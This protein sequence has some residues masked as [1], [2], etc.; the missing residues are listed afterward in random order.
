MA[1]FPVDAWL[2]DIAAAVAREPVVL[3]KADPGAGKTTRVPPALLK[4]F[5]SVLVVEPRRLAAKLTASWVADEMGSPVGAKVGYQ[6][7][8]ENRASSETRLLFVT[9]GI[10]SRKMMG[11]PQLRDW[12]VVI[13]D[14]F[15]ERH[16]HTDLALALLRDAQKSRPDLRIVIMSATLDTSRL[17]EWLGRSVRF[18]IPGRTF[19]VTVEY[20]PGD[21]LGRLEDKVANSVRELLADGRTG[22]GNV[23]VFLPGRAEIGRA[24]QKLDGLS[25]V[26]VI[27]L[28]A[29]QAQNHAL[30]AR[31]NGRRKVVLSTNVAETSLTLPRITAVV[32]TGLA[33]ISGHAP[34]S[35][36]P[37]LT[38]QKISQASCVQRTGRAGRTSAG[39][40]HRL[41]TPMDFNNRAKFGEP[42]IRR[43]DLCQ[44]LLEIA[45]IK[46][47]ARPWDLLPWFE[48]PDARILEQ[49]TKLLERL[50]AID[51]DGALTREGEAMASL[52]LHPRL[53]RMVQ[54]GK[55]FGHGEAAFLGALIINEG[56]LLGQETPP[57]EHARCDVAYQAGLFLDAKRRRLSPRIQLDRGKLARIEDLYRSLAPSWRLKPLTA[58]DEI[59]ETAMRRAIL[60]GFA[61]RAARY[62]PLAETGAR[63]LRPYNFCL[64]KGGVLAP[65]SVLDREEWIVVVEAREA[66]DDPTGTRGR[67]QAASAADAAWLREDP[68]RL[69][70]RREDAEVDGKSGKLKRIARTFYGEILF[71]EEVLGEE[72]GRAAQETFAMTLRKD[73][74]EA[75]G[76]VAALGAY[77]ARLDL[78]DRHG[79]VHKMPRFEGEMLDFLIHELCQGARS[80]AEIRGRSLEK[81]IMA[82]LDDED[83]WTLS[84]HCPLEVKLANGRKLRVTYGEGEPSVAARIQ[85]FYGQP[86]TPR[87]CEGMQPLLCKL[88]A[89][90]QRPAQ[91]TSDLRRFWEGSYHDVKKELKR[92]YPKHAW[93]DDPLNWTPPKKP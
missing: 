69:L 78:L 53:A 45:V 18:D 51:A 58:W 41:F 46:R 89:P 10:L 4:R 7:R 37:T 31:E 67:I 92:R 36:L 85:D 84:R 28:S 27:Q 5:R 47:G 35:G 43:I 23:L 64:G 77:H 79:I 20:R 71:A 38:V 12:D 33:R 3:I 90:S 66:V 6:I 57:L 22:D 56:M 52:P 62:R 1:N 91:I 32:D 42:E 44:V 93:P 24:A 15:H 14:E 54:A 76:D 49:D 75:F 65:G 86:D 59:D 80:L 70:T 87:I 39:V 11:D 9:E 26:D 60:A 74:P 13:L 30:I 16:I 81:S 55:D 68:F 48:T 21:A 25:S 34:G 17:E 61:D 8:L 88:L 29:E 19:P 83:T 72:K 63:N 40:C 2:D 50:G 82:Q 73:W